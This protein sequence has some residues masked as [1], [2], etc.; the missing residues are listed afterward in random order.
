MPFYKKRISYEQLTPMVNKFMES[1]RR[2]C[3]VIQ[4]AGDDGQEVFLVD[5]SAASEFSALYMAEYKALSMSGMIT[6]VP[7]GASKA[8]FYFDPNVNFTP[9]TVSLNYVRLPKLSFLITLVPEDF[10]LL[11]RLITTARNTPQK[12]ALSLDPAAC[13]IPSIESSSLSPFFTKLRINYR[14]TPEYCDK[15]WTP[16]YAIE[17]I[18]D[19]DPTRDNQL[20][21][22]QYFTVMQNQDLIYFP[23]EAMITLNLEWEQMNDDYCIPQNSQQKE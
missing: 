21:V 7:L 4:E 5:K 23:I 13:G 8:L 15:K 3:P 19:L 17:Q 2:M 22:M 14:M 18:A 11:M 6:Q 12:D 20:T 16:R 10:F 9:P 1:V